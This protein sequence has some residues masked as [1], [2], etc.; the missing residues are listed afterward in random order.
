MDDEILRAYAA[1]DSAI[2]AVEYAVG[3]F[4]FHGKKD[5]NFVTTVEWTGRPELDQAVIAYTYHLGQEHLAHMTNVD[6]EWLLRTRIRFP[7]FA[8]ETPVQQSPKQSLRPRLTTVP[9]LFAS[10]ADDSP[11]KSCWNSRRF[12]CFLA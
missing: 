6:A 8:G 1:A 4:L 11:L 5:Y 10:T 7:E 3:D 9:V 12:G 2:K